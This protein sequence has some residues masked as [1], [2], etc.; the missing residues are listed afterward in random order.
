MQDLLFAVSS[1]VTETINNI[2]M[3][4]FRGTKYKQLHK[5]HAKYQVFK[6]AQNFKNLNAKGLKIS[7]ISMQKG[8][9][10]QIFK[11]A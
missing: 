5:M 2:P 7:N 9:K 3:G 8:S 11:C 10:F 6:R 1:K 4:I